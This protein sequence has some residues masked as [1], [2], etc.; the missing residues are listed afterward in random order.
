MSADFLLGIAVGAFLMA[1]VVVVG[2]ALVIFIS[3]TLE[4]Q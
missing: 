1:A 3:K 4:D 2:C